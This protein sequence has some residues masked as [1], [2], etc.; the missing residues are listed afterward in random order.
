MDLA[1]ELNLADHQRRVFLQP[2]FLVVT[3]VAHQNRLSA[4]GVERRAIAD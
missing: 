1:A 4:D 2:I 3:E